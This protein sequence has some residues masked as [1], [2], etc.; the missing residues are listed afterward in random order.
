MLI[1]I[2]SLKTTKS[3]SPPWKS[4]KENERNILFGQ[5]RDGLA[6]TKAET[7]SS[8][9]RLRT[10]SLLPEQLVQ[11]AAHAKAVV[12]FENHAEKAFAVGL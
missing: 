11:L 3:S 9:P 10:A 12:V 7:A 1:H 2:I 8:L 5:L 4:K 6:T